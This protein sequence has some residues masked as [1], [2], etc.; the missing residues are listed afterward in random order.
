VMSQGPN[1][2][3]EGWSGA[4]RAARLARRLWAA[5]VAAADARAAVCRALRAEPLPPGPLAVIAVGK[6]AC[7]MAAGAREALGPRW[8]GAL[9]VSAPGYCDGAPPGGR[10]LQA[11]HPLPDEGSLAAGEA[12]AAAV[13]AVPPEGTV[14]FLV[15]GG[16]SA[17]LEL[18][19]PGHGL[20]DLARLNRWLL[21]SGLGIGAVNAVRR[22]VSALKGGR[23]AR[24]LR[25][26]AVVLA[27]SDV[28]GDDPAVIGSGPL[29]PP[30]PAAGLPEGLPAW[31]RSMAA[32]APPPP[33]PDDPVFAR[34][35][36]R[37]VASN[38]TA[39]AGVLAAAKDAGL[40]GTDHGLLDGEAADAGRRLGRWLA[41]AAPPGVH[42]WGGETP[43]R[44][45]AHPGR[46]GRCRQL[47][48]AAALALA[49][50]VGVA[51]AAG[52]TDGRDGTGEAA[53]GVVD[54]TTA[55]RARE[56]GCEPEAALADA[57]AGACL[58]AAGAALPARATG[59]NVMD[60]VVGVRLP[61]G[62]AGAEAP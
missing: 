28:P 21:A 25:A 13:A 12:V 6:A 62:A 41:E 48:L 46:G 29:A 49:G 26:R 57:D 55:A 15:S 32:A 58:E 43:V 60:L 51:L 40:A 2:E 22:A 16:A 8:P 1:P 50:R 30:P 56:G 31:V 34:I 18:P 19:P 52:G 59:T 27:V 42:V 5:G 39:R 54:G 44:L 35:R 36:H 38:A 47:A 11:G 33:P 61:N 9:V 23:L 37:V 7:A 45:P 20:D 24:R 14:L 53:G 4:R 3:P 10:L 17:M